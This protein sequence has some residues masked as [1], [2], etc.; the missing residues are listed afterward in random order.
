MMGEDARKAFADLGYAS[1]ADY[2]R[3][4]YG[5]VLREYAGLPDLSL[6]LSVRPARFL[7]PSLPPSLDGVRPRV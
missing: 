7:P 6:P 3:A 5:G 1:L 2:V 4:G